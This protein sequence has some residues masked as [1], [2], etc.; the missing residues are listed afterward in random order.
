MKYIK[1]FDEHANYE[2]Y[3]DSDER[4]LPN[5]SYCITENETHMLNTDPFNGFTRYIDFGLPSGTLWSFEFLKERDAIIYLGWGEIT[6]ASHLENIGGQAKHVFDIAHY[7]YGETQ[8]QV[9]TMTKYNSQDNKT[10]LDLDD[11]FANKKLGGNWHIPTA[12][13]VQELFDNTQISYNKNENAFLISNQ[14][15][16]VLL[17]LGIGTDAGYFINDEKQYSDSLFVFWTKDINP[18]LYLEAQA[19][20]FNKNGGPRQGDGP[21][22]EITNMA[23]FYGLPILPVIDQY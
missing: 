18:D 21:I 1:L 8:E 4:I 17:S 3:M 22:Y 5:I 19:A 9:I 7:K 15:G 11:D 13:Q 10:S 23:R 14:Y 2:T 12:A 16:N 6:M 20:K